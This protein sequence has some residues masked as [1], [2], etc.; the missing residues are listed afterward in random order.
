MIMKGLQLKFGKVG[1]AEALVASHSFGDSRVDGRSQTP[2]AFVM[3]PTPIGSG[4]N[5]G[6]NE[7]S[8]DN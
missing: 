8:I 4:D 7:E 5:W 2:A 6:Q 1:L 3:L